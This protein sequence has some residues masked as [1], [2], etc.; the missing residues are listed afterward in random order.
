M[1]RP[2]VRQP[3]EINP[4]QEEAERERLAEPCVVVI[5]GA[6]GDLTRRKLVPALYDLVREGLLPSN[7]TIVGFARR[8]LSDAAFRAQLREGVEQFAEARPLHPELW[9]DF[10]AGI[11]YLAA[12][13]EDPM[14]YR[15]LAR[16]LDRLDAE[17]GTLGNR[18]FYLAT[19]PSAYAP[20]IAQ[21]GAAGLNRSTGWARIIVEKPFGHD[22]QS[23][24]ELNEQLL[25][26][27]RES[28]VFRIDH[29]LGKETVQNILALRFGNGIFEPLWNRQFIDHVQIAVAE[30]IGVE[31]RGRYYEEAGA[32]RDMVQSHMFQ[33]L[34]LVAM[35]PPALFAATAVRNEKVKVLQSIRPI[36]PEQVAESTVRAQY[37][38]G[39]TGSGIVRGYLEEPGVSLAS[40]TET[41]VALQ[42]EIDN[43]RWAGVPF[44]LRHG[45]RLARRE[46]QIAIVFRL[47]PTMLFG[48]N[49]A[50]ALEPNVLALRIQPDP[51]ISLRFGAK[52]PGPA[53]RLRAV[54]MDFLYGASFGAA[55]HDAYE[56]LL[57]DAILG[58]STLFTR[59]DEVEAAWALIDPIREGW[60]TMKEAPLPTYLAGSWGPAA[61]AGFIAREGR[62]WVRL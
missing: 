49:G 22:L 56:R 3:F 23:A 5:F 32:L 62:K 2:Q 43:W 50:S 17:R 39:P 45:K 20:I 14:G 37:V 40:R 7:V 38:A 57:L 51:G 53:M 54:H 13:F 6:T 36:R 25:A 41:Y 10:A 29:Y 30:S 19:P 24:H 12:D 61:S 34:S 46:T 1:V 18:L 4:F 26:V 28:Q 52:V 8:P 21:L 59:R 31:G 9:E 55:E 11:T 27:F 35:E 16:L 47:P 33:L 44:Y 15:E 48:R 42:L 58:D 60:Q